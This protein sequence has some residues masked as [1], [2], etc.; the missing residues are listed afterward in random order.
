MVRKTDQ[1]DEPPADGQAT[2]G[3]DTVEPVTGPSTVQQRFEQSSTFA[4]RAG[5]QAPAQGTTEANS[6]FASRSSK[7]VTTGEG[8]A[9]QSSE[10]K[11]IQFGDTK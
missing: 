1:D 4:G 11:S 10:N 3:T 8:K 7:R 5:K 6:T 2:D 9:V